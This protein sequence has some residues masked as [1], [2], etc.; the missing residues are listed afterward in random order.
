MG[1]LNKKINCL[2]LW[3]PSTVSVSHNVFIRQGNWQ[4][5]GTYRNKSGV[6]C[7]GARAQ[8]N[9]YVCVCVCVC[10]YESHSVVSDFL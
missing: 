1:H 6:V 4:Q 8:E 5:C 2:T 9:S 10:V 7:L 3:I